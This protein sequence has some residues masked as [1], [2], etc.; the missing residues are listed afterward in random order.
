MA[1]TTA[2]AM[3]NIGGMVKYGDVGRAEYGIIKRVNPITGQVFCWYHLGDTAAGASAEQLELVVHSPRWY[4]YEPALGSEPRHEDA[5]KLVALRERRAGL[6][7]HVAI[8]D[9][10][11]Y[12]ADGE[13]PAL[14][15]LLVIFGDG[16]TEHLNLDEVWA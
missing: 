3:L 9:R 2:E 16:H 11:D 13:E 10:Y 5:G 4:S 1:M 7:E 8:I 14:S 12:P 15:M 6:V